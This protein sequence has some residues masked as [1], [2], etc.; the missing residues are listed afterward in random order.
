MI[1]SEYSPHLTQVG[2][3]LEFEKVL[4]I[5]ADVIFCVRVKIAMIR[6]APLVVG[7]NVGVAAY[8]RTNAT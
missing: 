2:I 3:C 6:W 8:Q 5:S 4:T 7:G 1:L